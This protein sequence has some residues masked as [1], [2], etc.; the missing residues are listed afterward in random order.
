MNVQFF[1]PTAMSCK[2][3]RGRYLERADFHGARKLHAGRRST[4]GEDMQT[5]ATCQS[6]AQG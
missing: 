1:P 4:A 2:V 5:N 3:M 6:G